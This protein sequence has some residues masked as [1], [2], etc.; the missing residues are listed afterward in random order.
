MV[1]FDLTTCTSDELLSHLTTI[2]KAAVDAEGTIMEA[3]SYGK[4]VDETEVS[5]WLP[6]AI[7]L[8]DKLS[9]AGSSLQWAATQLQRLAVK[10]KE[11]G[12]G[13]DDVF[14]EVLH[15][16]GLIDDDNN[17]NALA[18]CEKFCRER[19]RLMGIKL[20]MTLPGVEP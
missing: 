20:T 19:S 8:G 12:S 3:D 4:G 10:A 7:D 2:V 9:T 11:I 17:R 13:L 16:L 14:C 1:R 18:L 6:A 15:E 5:D